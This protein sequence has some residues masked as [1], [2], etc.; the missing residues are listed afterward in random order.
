MFISQIVLRNNE[1]SNA[2]RFESF[3][4]A[5]QTEGT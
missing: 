5:L 4:L 2:H 1:L 3:Q